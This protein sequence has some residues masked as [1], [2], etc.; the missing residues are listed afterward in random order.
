MIKVRNLLWFFSIYLLLP[1]LG[2]SQSLPTFSYDEVVFGEEK[3]KI[4]ELV[5]AAGAHIRTASGEVRNS[6]SFSSLQELNTY[7][8]LYS[9]LGDGLYS[10]PSAELYGYVSSYGLNSNLVSTIDYT[11]DYPYGVV[12]FF[13]DDALNSRLFMVKRTLERQTI[14]ART[15]FNLHRSGIDRALG[16]LGEAHQ[17]VYNH[18]NLGSGLGLVGLW[19]TNDR[20]VILLTNDLYGISSGPT[21]IYLDLSLWQEYLSMVEAFETSRRQENQDGVKGKF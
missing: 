7:T 9:E 17:V 13:L 15:D 16:V 4:I 1:S 3:S 11:W 21:Y 18:P 2:Y 19:D 20:L 8:G 14:D 10:Y 5:E 6:F 12:L